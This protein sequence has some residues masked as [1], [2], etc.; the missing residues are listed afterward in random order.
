MKIGDASLE[1]ARIEAGR[2]TLVF[3]H[4]GLGAA[5]SWRD[6]PRELS[7]ATGCSA[8]AYS[9]AGYGRSSPRRQPM[10]P[11][12]LDAEAAVLDEILTR[13][14][15][16]PYV[17]VGHSDGASIAALH[18]TRPDPELLGIVLIAPHAF[19]EDMCVTRIQ[20]DL[21]ERDALEE[22]LRVLH[23][24][25]AGSLL[26]DWSRVWTSEAFRRRPLVPAI[27]AIR[28]PVLVIQGEQD[29]YGT[30]AQVD[31]FVDG[32]GASSLVL[33]ECGHAPQRDHPARVREAI[34]DFV[35]A[36]G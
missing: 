32:C 13:V 11:D 22:R 1:T 2:P 21:E 18:A 8:F 34:L 15:A 26:D 24:E 4:A 14:A 17:L 30:L 28:C 23:G 3:L 25:K 6:L 29:A 9:R 5:A 27:A 7:E 31:A 33:P 36:L 35:T 19:V 12:F 10:E 16:P 20:A